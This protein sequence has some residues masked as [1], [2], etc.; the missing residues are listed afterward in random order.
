LLSVVAALVA[1]VTMA[2][3]CVHETGTSTTAPAH[4]S[5]TAS[6]SATITT[7][8]PTT[9]P[10]GAGTSTSTT[11][12]G[13]PVVKIGALFP[14][15]GDL[16][17]EGQSALKGMRLAVEEVNADGGITAL[18][19]ARL[20]LVEAD[21][22]G[23]ATTADALVAHLAQSDGV[24]AIVGAGQSTV[25]LQ[26]T[27]AAERLQIP[28]MVSSGAALEITQRNLGYT[29]R[30]CPEAD[31]YARDQV[32][33]LQALNGLAARD[34]TSVALLHE[35]GEF[36]K[37]TAA[38]QKA[39][40]ARAG[41]QVAA[42]IEYSPGKADLS[43]EVLAIRQ[44]GAQAILTATLLSDATVIA[45]D[46][47]VLH[48]NLPIIDA[49]GGV[50]DP[51]FIEEAGASSEEMMSVAEVAPGMAPSRDLEQKLSVSGTQLDS[52][53]LY[54][55][56]AVWV[57][58]SALERAG[59]AEGPALRGALKTTALYGDHLVLPQSLL[60]FDGTGQNRE[61]QLLVLQVQD[62]KMVTVWPTEYAPGTV[63][64]P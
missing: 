57:L 55:Y 48:M 64:L 49:A 61:A 31:W 19:G 17:A 29:F 63:R 20:T 53:L 33:F 1:V 43:N 50:L 24:A 10:V 40:L 23:D 16:A 18:N 42:D 8:A 4:G 15:T 47:S 21:S 11:T 13:P 27:D 54:A 52:D 32:A 51:G 5:T 60:T 34:I 37:Q 26:A 45:E 25:A 2:A 56:Q 59:S 6:G 36:G 12:A 14:L 46:A 35:N 39:Y 22:K 44:S 28:F 41:I 38:S 62:G 30:L 9:Q 7:A 58:A 3:G